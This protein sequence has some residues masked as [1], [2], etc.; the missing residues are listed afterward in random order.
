[1]AKVC[2]YSHTHFYETLFPRVVYEDY[3]RKYQREKSSH[4]RIPFEDAVRFIKMI[5]GDFTDEEAREKLKK[6]LSE[7]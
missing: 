4:F 6:V 2:S 3:R 7:K 1:M 5:R